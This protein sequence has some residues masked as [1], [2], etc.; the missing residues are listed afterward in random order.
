MST[1]TRG[2]SLSPLEL[3]GWLAFNGRRTGL[4]AV[5]RQTSA[6]HG[7]YVR[8]VLYLDG[9]GRV[10][11]P[12]GNPYLPVT[13]ISSRSSPSGRTAAWHRAAGEIVAEM[14]DRGTVNAVTFPPE[15]DDVRPW[16]WEG[17]LAGV[18]YTYYLDLP[19]DP[20]AMGSEQRRLLRKAAASGLTV[21][22]TDDVGAVM[23]CLDETEARQGFSHRLDERMLRE[24]RA[25]VGDEHLRM[26]LCRTAHGRPASA[27]T[28]LHNP[29][30][31]AIWWVG[32]SLAEHLSS[33]AIGLVLRQAF[34]DLADAGAN[35]IDMAGANIRSVAAFKAHWGPRLVPQYSVQSFSYR[36]LALLA[37][38]SW[39]MPR[40][41]R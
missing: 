17:F 13:F 4:T 31:R 11:S 8:A 5:V 28:F 29:G 34:D 35:G 12:T 19:F 37:R 32:G 39:S 3:P 16:S 24:A 21:E 25:I 27:V 30:A 22:R 2:E 1:L 26:Y 15:I 14:R 18:H 41:R 7:S 9:R 40:R 38:R 20:A 10:R 6:D 23:A 36:T 33:N